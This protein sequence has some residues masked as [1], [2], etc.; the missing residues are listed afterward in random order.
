PQPTNANLSNSAPSSSRLARLPRI[1]AAGAQHVHD[2]LQT[3][4]PA[5][6]VRVVPEASWRRD[7]QRLELGFG[8]LEFLDDVAPVLLLHLHRIRLLADFLESLL[9]RELTR[10]D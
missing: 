5:E 2:P 7:H 4:D 8:Q 3:L 6:I 10:V 1:P 9:A